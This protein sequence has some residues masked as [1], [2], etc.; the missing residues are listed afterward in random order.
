MKQHIAFVSLILASACS[1]GAGAPTTDAAP[2]DSSAVDAPAPGAFSVTTPEVTIGAGKE[3]T[4]RYYTTFTGSKALG[5]KRWASVMTPG[6]HHLIMY[7]MTTLPKPAGTLE[8]GSCQGG[9]SLQ[10]LPVWTYSAQTPTAESPMPPGVGMQVAANQGI[11]VEM[12]YLNVTEAALKAHVQVTGDAYAEGVAYQKAAAFITYNTQI[13]IP[14][15]GTATAGGE[16][17]V[18]AG[19]KFFAMSTHV[20]KQ[21]IKTQVKDG[22]TMLFEATDW[23]HPGTKSWTEPFYSFASNKLS[24]QCDYRNPTN[25]TV[26]E[27]QSAETDEMCMAVGYFFPAEKAK[28]CINSFSVP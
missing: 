5:I 20:H 10:N 2:V 17:D 19:A 1:G 12:H 6:S 21:G 24:Y 26:T 25:R 18:P 7:F 28:M 4:W 11:C 8:Q 3:E 13:S 22:A 27:G 16:C 9:Q 23:E 14:P 15:G